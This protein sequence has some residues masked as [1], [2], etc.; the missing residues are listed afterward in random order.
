[1]LEID[2]MET[3]DKRIFDCI[4][5]DL[6]LP[7][8]TGFET[9]E[10]M[11]GRCEK[12]AIVVITGSVSF[13]TRS[14]AIEM[15]AQAFLLKDHLKHDK[16]GELISIIETSVD[17]KR[18]LNNSIDKVKQEGSLL[19]DSISKLQQAVTQGND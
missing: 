8:S 9:L 15:G 13:D 7:D 1:M 4:L 17:N 3:G 11:N 6:N 12:S 19:D 2:K 10:K 14:K 5:L 18:R 16:G